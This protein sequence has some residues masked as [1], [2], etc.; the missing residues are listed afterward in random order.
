[1]IVGIVGAESTGKSTLAPALAQR[2]AA[3]SGLRCVAVGEHLRRWCDERGRT[4]QAHE[5]AAIARRQAQDI[6]AALARHDVVVADTTPLMVAVYSLLLFDDASL[7]DAAIAF[8]RRCAATLLT[9]LDLPWVADGHQRDGEHVREPVDA[10]VR[11]L[12]AGHGLPWSVVCGSGERRIE[13]A[14]DAVAPLLR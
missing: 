3:A 13:H 9:G 5:Q 7:V 8:Q 6:D 4:P 11:A 1:M 2:I 10:R 14:F 12:L